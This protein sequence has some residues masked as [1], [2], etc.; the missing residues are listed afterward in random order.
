MTDDAYIKPSDRES[1]DCYDCGTTQCDCAARMS[2]SHAV[3]DSVAADLATVLRDV[4]TFCDCWRCL[5]DAYDGLC[6]YGEKMEKA[7]EA[8]LQRF[9]NLTKAEPNE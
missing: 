5:S 1:E 2:A 3:V 4:E 7:A 6:G 8:A 9:D